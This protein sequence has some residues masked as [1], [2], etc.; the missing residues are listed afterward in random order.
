M[1]LH[2]HSLRLSK[3]QIELCE[4]LGLD[5]TD[6]VLSYYPIRYDSFQETPFTSWAIKEHVTFE[7]RVA[8][9]PRSWRHGRLVTT[10]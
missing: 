10:N 9:L 2:D 8:S 3:K 7:A 5:D 6:A 1:D 4:A